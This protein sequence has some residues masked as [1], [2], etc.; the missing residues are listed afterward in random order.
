MRRPSPPAAGFG[1][2]GVAIIGTLAIGFGAICATGFVLHLGETA[3][4]TRQIEERRLEVQAIVDEA[5]ERLPLL[6][7]R[8]ELARRDFQAAGAAVVAAEA[9]IA[10]IQGALDLGLD[11]TASLDQERES[12]GKLSAAQLFESAGVATGRR[13]YIDCYGGAL[14]V[15]PGGIRIVRSAIS[16]SL[17]DALGDIEHV[18]ILVRPDGFGTFL[19]AEA[20]LR[21]QRSE[22]SLGYLPVQ[23]DWEFDFGGES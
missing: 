18:M 6:E 1:W 12:A 11:R 17:A 21:E 19:E 15:E 23:T 20:L 2:S 8:I 7:D 13:R 5:E 14:V 16:R 10:G 4:K 9:E 3:A 22:V